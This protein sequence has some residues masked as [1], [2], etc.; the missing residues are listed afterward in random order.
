MLDGTRV[1]DRTGEIAGPYC[2]KLLADAGA[3]VVRVEP[4]GGDPLR[5]WRSGALFDFLNASKRSVTEVGELLAGAD[6]LVTDRPADVDPLWDANPR[7]SNSST[8]CSPTPRIMRRYSL[9]TGSSSPAAIA[10]AIT[11]RPRRS[12]AIASGTSEKKS[13]GTRPDMA[14]ITT[15]MWCDRA[16]ATI[17]WWNASAS[18]VKSSGW[19]AV[20][21][22]STICASCSTSTPSLERRNARSAANPYTRP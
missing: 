15:L 5:R 16:P 9:A 1:L 20:G 4:A 19:V 18:R 12:M 11:G 17:A 10:R 21:R 6:L 13:P 22:S 3:D 2:T 7:L 14:R 8:T